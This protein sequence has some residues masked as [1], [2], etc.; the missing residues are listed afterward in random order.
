[1]LYI[2]LFVAIIFVALVSIGIYFTNQ[3]M[4]MKKKTDLDIIKRET[5]Y[6]FFNEKDFNNAPKKEFTLS[7]K[8]GYDIKGFTLSP[9]KHNRHMIICHGVTVNHLNSVKY[10]NLFLKLG[11]NVVVYDHRRHGKSGGKTTSFGHFEKDDLKTVVDWVKLQYGKDAYI[12]IHGESMGSATTLLYAGMVEDGADFYILDCPFANFKD[13]LAH[14]LKHDYHLPTF[15]F[16]QIGELF[17]KIREGYTLKDVSPIS[18]IDKIKKPALFIHSEPDTYI[19]YSMTLQLF[20]KKQGEKQLFIAKKGAH[21]LSY[22]ENKLEYEQVIEQFLKK[23]WSNKQ[24]I[25]IS[26]RS[27]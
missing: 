1:M 22:S 13:Q 2:V 9:H 18:H 15:P 17:L 7:S 10:M 11:W 26:S 25:N 14:L 27:S 4:Y 8:H 3:L 6:G 23:I 19:P 5:A 12:G 20:E 16:I 21:A 24:K